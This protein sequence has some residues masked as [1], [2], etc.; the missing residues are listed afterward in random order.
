MFAEER[1]DVMRVL[2]RLLS[3]DGRSKNFFREVGG[4]V[5]VLS[6]LVTL[7]REDRAAELADG[8][9]DLFYCGVLCMRKH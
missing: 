8:E 9:L 4:F 7:A 6:S 5:Y 3:T 2:M 1:V